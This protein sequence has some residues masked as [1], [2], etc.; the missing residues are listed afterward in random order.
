VVIHINGLPCHSDAAVGMLYTALLCKPEGHSKSAHRNAMHQKSIAKTAPTFVSAPPP[1]TS[2]ACATQSTPQLPAMPCLVHSWCTAASNPCAARVARFDRSLAAGK[3]NRRALLLAPLR[4]PCS[5]PA[6]TTAPAA[7]AAPLHWSSSAPAMLSDRTG[8]GCS[9][10]SAALRSRALL[11][12]W[13]ASTQTL[14]L[15]CSLSAAVLLLMLLT[16]DVAALRDAV[17]RG[18]PCGFWPCPAWIPVS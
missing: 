6:L 4:T 17:L 1:S 18:E 5:A 11:L 3:P 7:L 10:V 16:A 12:P 15:V 8:A 2:P 14:F 13:G 9:A